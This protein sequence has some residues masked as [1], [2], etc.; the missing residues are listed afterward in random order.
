M[1]QVHNL[2]PRYKAYTYLITF[3]CIL[4]LITA[5][6]YKEELLP[7]LSNGFVIQAAAEKYNIDVDDCLKCQE[8]GWLF[9]TILI[10]YLI[11][12]LLLSFMVPLMLIATVVKLIYGTPFL[13]TVKVFFTGKY[14]QHW[15]MRKVQ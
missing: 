1:N 4:P 11:F 10:S 7:V 12:L 8:N 6:I 15:L 3:L 14:P 5:C 13:F 9:V 2:K